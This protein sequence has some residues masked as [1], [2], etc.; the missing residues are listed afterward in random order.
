[1]FL[2]SDL[3]DF[4]FYSTKTDPKT[5]PPVFQDYPSLG[6]IT[7]KMSENNINLVFAVTSYVVPLYKVKY[8]KVINVLQ[9]EES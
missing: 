4:R 2:K 1:M 6:L 8:R 9:C 5:D 7:D 3:I